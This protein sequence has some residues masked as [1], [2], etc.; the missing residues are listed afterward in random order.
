M[1][2]TDD[3]RRRERKRLSVLKNV[4]LAGKSGLVLDESYVSQPEL[5]SLVAEGLLAGISGQE[6]RRHQLTNKGHKKLKQLIAA[7]KRG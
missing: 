3:L 7:H 4:K 5:D 2:T 1:T 6:E